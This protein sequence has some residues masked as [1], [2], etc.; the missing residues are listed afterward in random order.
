M[1]F[2]VPL[3]RDE[4]QMLIEALEDVIADGH[5]EKTSH[6]GLHERLF[7]FYDKAA[8]ADPPITAAEFTEPVFFS[9][10]FNREED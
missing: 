8:H 9:E 2:D 10:D 4:I 1:R 5:V 7:A 3:T 6:L